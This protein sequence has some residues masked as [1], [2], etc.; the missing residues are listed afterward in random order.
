M[1]DEYHCVL[2]LGSIMLMISDDC[3]CRRWS[4]C[5]LCLQIIW[6]QLKWLPTTIIFF[7]SVLF[8]M[9][10][11]CAIYFLGLPVVWGA[12]AKV[13]HSLCYCV[14][15][16]KQLVMLFCHQCNQT[17]TLLSKP[18]AVCLVLKTCQKVTSAFPFLGCFESGER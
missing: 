5:C 14:N 18:G 8:H 16:C 7:N 13:R 2:H 15:L 1:A 9:T 6:E 17:H 3:C 4:C 12:T 10:E 11:V